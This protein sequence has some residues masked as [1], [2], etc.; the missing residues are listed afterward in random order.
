[1]VTCPAG[2]ATQPDLERED[3]MRSGTMTY[4]LIALVAGVFAGTSTAGVIEVKLGATVGRTWEQAK[5]DNYAYGPKQEYDAKTG[6]THVYLPYGTNGGLYSSVRGTLSNAA[7]KELAQFVSQDGNTSSVLAYAL[8]FDRRIGSFRY[9]AGWSEIGLSETTVAGV[10]Y[11]TD[12]ADWKPMVEIKG[13]KTAIIE[14][15]V[16]DFKAEGLDTDTL[17]I[18]YYTRDPN[19]PE[20]DGPGRWL[21]LRMSGDPSW[22]DAATTFFSCQHQIWVTASKGTASAE[23]AAGSNASAA[24]RSTAASDDASPWGMGTSAEWSGE[25]PK[26]NPMLRGA[27][28]TW[29]RQFPEWQTI[30][31]KRGQWNWEASDR[32]VANARTNG[33]RVFPTW[34]YFAPWA[35]AD[36]GTRKGPIKDM[37]FWREYVGAT[38]GRYR[39]DI[40]YWEV[41]NEFNGSFYEGPNKAKEYADLVVAAY[42]TAK[43]IDPNVKIAMS[44][45]NFD[46]AFLDAAIKAGAAG[47][48]DLVC[49]H[50]YENLG[51]LAEG[52]EAG[53]LSL[54]QNLRDMLKANGQPV[55]TPL[56]I[57]EVGYPAPIKAEPKGDALEAEILAKGFVLS[58][59][60][61]F[62]RV[63]WFE[64][65]GP[66]YGSGTDLGI[67][68]PDWTPRPA[69]HALKTMTALMGAQPKYAGWLDLGQ[70]GYG[71]V[72]QGQ[73]GNVLAAWAPPGKEHQATFAADVRVTDLAGKESTLASGRP[74]VLTRTPV[75]VTNLPVDLVKQAAANRSKPYPWGGDYARAKV[76]TCRLGAVNRDDGLKQVN[77]NT[78]VVVNGLAETCRRTDFANPALKSEG[79]YV[80][81]RVDPL[82]VPFGTKDLAITIVARR[83]AR[84]KNAGM[85]LMYEST[86]GYKGANQWFTIP[87]GDA[88]HEYTWKV[89]DASF[90][91]QWGYNFRFDAI[92]SPN[93][94]LIK[95]VRVTKGVG[96]GR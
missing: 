44:V 37:E 22:G 13:P 54:A 84:G 94:F 88:W 29:V 93:E 92:S 20:A 80:Y 34:C 56:W 1:M 35:S 17:Y 9:W 32:I 15:L 96:A 76:V 82:F 89:S 7:A 55:D 61:G 53:Y 78:T 65:R 6:Q 85:N 8:H 74:L 91:G 57:T 2:G 3:M 87:E 41:W 71:F 38:V 40:Q 48:F 19:K 42:D 58:L 14:P 5:A 66:S 72:F 75:F 81:F 33:L 60:Q 11:S 90:V 36:G 18:R 10:E 77:P 43:K 70:G 62:Q 30:E 51:S 16:G 52:G 83:V 73:A 31:P 28:V 67:I 21:K 39:K 12:G 68:R 63:F 26:F 24:E 46:V 27:G 86:K 25:Y 45:A 69:Y 95:E 50:P 47:H 49:V 79:H 23:P 64:A 4:G 59:A